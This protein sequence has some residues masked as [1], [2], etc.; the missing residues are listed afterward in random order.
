MISSLRPSL[1]GTVG[2]STLQTAVLA[3]VL[4]VAAHIAPVL[5]DVFALARTAFVLHC[6]FYHGLMANL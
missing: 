3:A 4:L 2:S 6:H 5:D 1:Y